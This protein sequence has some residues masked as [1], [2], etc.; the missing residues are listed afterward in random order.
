M[1]EMR[2]LE[3]IKHP[4]LLRSYEFLH[5]AKYYYIVTELVNQGDLFN[6]YCQL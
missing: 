1:N 6:Y 5:D 4:N 2:I 3:Q